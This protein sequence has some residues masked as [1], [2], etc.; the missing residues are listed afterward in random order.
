MVRLDETLSNDPVARDG[1]V[2]RFPVPAH[3]LRTVQVVLQ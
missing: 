2:V 1:R 3:A